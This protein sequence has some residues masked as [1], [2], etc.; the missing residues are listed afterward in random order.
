MFGC[1]GFFGGG[2]GREVPFCLAAVKRRKGLFSHQGEKA[3]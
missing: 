3:H 2:K 1:W